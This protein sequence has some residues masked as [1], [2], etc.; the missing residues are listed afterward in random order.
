[1]EKVPMTAE[2]YRALDDQ[3]KQ[4][5]QVERPAVIAAIAEAREHG[6]LSENAE[7][8]AAKERQGWVEGSIAEI[9]DKLSRAQVIDVA[10]LSGNTVKFGATV[11]LVDE[12]TE[13]ES[14][15]KIVGDD[16]ADVKARKISISSPI[17]RALISKEVG[18]VVE[19]NTPGGV[20]GYEI[21][22]VEWK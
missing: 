10:K 20:K 4:L 9:E 22:K 2:G 7:Y 6:D 19:V 18:D 8:H 11:H 5:K 15:Y 14:F 3:L 13:E 1:M 21:L 12:D 16:E 17:A